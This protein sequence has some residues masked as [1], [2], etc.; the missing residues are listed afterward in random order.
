L[1]IGDF[2]CKIS[3]DFNGKAEGRAR[4]MA[5]R[6][7]PDHRRLVDIEDALIWAFREELPKRS[8]DG[9]VVALGSSVSPMWR[10][11]V[12]GAR[13]DNWSREPGFPAVLGDPHP[14]AIAIESRC[15]RSSASKA[16]R[17]MTRRGSRSASRGFAPGR[18]RADPHYP[19]EFNVAGI[20]GEASNMIVGWVANGARLRKR[21]EVDRELPKPARVL[22]SCGLRPL[23]L[24]EVM[25][26]NKADGRLYPALQPCTSFS[27]RRGGRSYP[28]GAFCPLDW[29]P[30]PKSVLRDRAEFAV[31][32]F[33]L[34]VL[35]GELVDL[36]SMT[37]LPPSAPLRPW[38]GDRDIG[39][40]PA[41]FTGLRRGRT[42][43][44][45]P[46]STANAGPGASHARRRHGR[47]YRRRN[48]PPRKVA[49]N[50]RR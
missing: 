1:G 39:K 22:A 45:A 11:G 28:N 43:K 4:E 7:R 33:A 9:N 30:N 25:M 16:F 36:E 31:W 26:R 50:S 27:L 19:A 15:S 17:S 41:L 23:V 12:F 5:D 21:P 37:V 44:A 29:I 8:P 34:E 18:V 24:R 40:P 2:R 3:Q 35:A 47:R 38:A 13:I 14:D 46:S 10:Y 48:R 49:K 42:A 20:I 6:K 32:R